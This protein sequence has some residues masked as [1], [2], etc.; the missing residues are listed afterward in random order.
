[1]FVTENYVVIINI[2]ELTDN[3][4]WDSRFSR[5]YR[6]YGILYVYAI[7]FGRHISSIFKVENAYPSIKI[8]GVISKKF[9][10]CIIP[11]WP[12]KAYLKKNIRLSQYL[13]ARSLLTGLCKRWIIIIIII[14]VDLITVLSIH[15]VRNLHPSQTVSRITFRLSQE[16]E[17]HPIP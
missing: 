2:T 15:L 4:L 9:V 3:D 17:A 10:M 8:H 7:R 11:A 13:S 1:M 12:W 14:I 16:K 6:E 5:W